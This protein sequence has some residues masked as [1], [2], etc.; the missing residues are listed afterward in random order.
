ML[1]LLIFMLVFLSEIQ[2][3]HSEIKEIIT[4]EKIIDWSKTVVP[5]NQKNQ[6]IELRGKIFQ[7]EYEDKFSPRVFSRLSYLK[8]HEDAFISFQPVISPQQLVEVGVEKKFARGLDATVAVSAD[9]REFKMNGQNELRDIAYASVDLSLDLWKNILGRMDQEEIKVADSYWKQSQ[10]QSTVANKIF[11]IKARS[12]Y[13]KLVANSESIK[14]STELLKTAKKQE[15]DAQARFKSSVADRGEVA[16]YSAQAADRSTGLTQLG[17]EREN[18]I[19]SLVKLFPTL[20]DKEVLLGDYN[21][22]TV[23]AQ[24]LQCVGTIEKYQQP[25]MENTLY[26]ELIEQIDVFHQNRLKIAEKYNSPDV[27]FVSKFFTNAVAQNSSD[28]FDRAIN[29]ST[30]GYQLG[31]SISIPL[32]KGDTQDSK[33]K[34]EILENEYKKK[35]TLLDLHASHAFIQK[36]IKFL[37][38]AIRDQRSS[39]ENLVVRL[40]EM[41]KKYKQGRISVGEFIN[42]QDRLLQTEIQLIETKSAILENLMSY[43]TIY[44]ETPCSF[45]GK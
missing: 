13:W 23:V 38:A 8:T 2:L 35:E 20:Q 11:E 27:K 25:P 29:K 9:H 1:K 31:L 26:D 41:E 42:D 6:S 39:K 15:L 12:I 18:L 3:S 33:T 16:R 17:Y 34:L 21:L 24:V 10:I 37:L 30:Q 28:A 4:E 32:G 19:K 40:K 44:T 22:D 5:E 43:L 36:S 45:N 14:I 7:T